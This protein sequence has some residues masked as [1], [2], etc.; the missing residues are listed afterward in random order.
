MAYKHWKLRNRDGLIGDGYAHQV[1]IVN[2]GQLEWNLF[3]LPEEAQLRLIEKHSPYASKNMWRISLA[4]S[5]GE[6]ETWFKPMPEFG[7]TGWMLA[8]MDFVRQA[9][10]HRGWHQ[11]KDGIFAIDLP[12]FLGGGVA[13][14]DQQAFGEYA[15]K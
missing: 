8:Y 5:I 10:R 7:T 6:L 11:R 9:M 1:H 4:N 15:S 13:Q 2:P 12:D 3:L 14:F